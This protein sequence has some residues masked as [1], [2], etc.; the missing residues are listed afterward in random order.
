MGP[1]VITQVSIHFQTKQNQTPQ[2][3]FQVSRKSYDPRDVRCMFILLQWIK[4]TQ[5]NWFRHEIIQ[6]QYG[7]V[8][9][10]CRLCVLIRETRTVVICVF[11]GRLSVDQGGSRS[12]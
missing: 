2:N 10:V 12:P 6:L 3:P 8:W 5:W 1:T 11:R 9:Y 4:I 7:M